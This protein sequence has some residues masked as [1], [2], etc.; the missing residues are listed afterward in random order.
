MNRELATKILFIFLAVAAAAWTEVSS[1]VALLAG[2]VFAL[3]LGNPFAAKTP[4]I[5][6]KL[7]SYSV[8]GLGAGMDL[9]EVL[10][11]GAQGLGVTC[12]TI[13]ATL[14]VGMGLGRLFKV[15]RYVAMLTSAGT[16]ICG[17]SA[18]AATAVAI[19]APSASV[20]VALA[21]VF[22]LNATALW[23]FPWIGS[24]LH[25][26]Q[27]AFGYW[28]A[29]AIHDTS[30]VVGASL[31]Y[32]PEALK[33]ATTVKLARALWIVPMTLVIGHFWKRP[34]GAP[35]GKVKRPWFIL[36]FLLMAALMTFV[37]ALKPA[38][39]WITLVA[40]RGLVLVLFLIG[41]GLTRETIK[42]TGPRPFLLGLVLWIIVGATSLALV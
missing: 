7:L 12:L 27:E 32:G 4:K 37:P 30:S 3:T 15:E 42:K 23:I 6:P 2:L 18:I 41:A 17:G 25:L 39:P 31:S 35:A 22:F 1:G 11:V 5:T 34:E 16:A 29:L 9:I 14:V 26:S 38:A 13:S 8:V 28:A 33:I 40:R 20:A 19:G 10:K 21:T 24:A 36:G